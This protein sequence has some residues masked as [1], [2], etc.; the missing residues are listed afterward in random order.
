MKFWKRHLTTRL[1]SY[2]LLLSLVTVSAVSTVAYLQARH[3]LKASAFNQLNVAATLKEEEI[4]RWFEDQQRDFLLTMQLPEVQTRLQTLLT[5]PTSDPE[6]RQVKQNLAQYF[7]N[8]VDLKPN[9]QEV[10]VLDNSGRILLSS[11]PQREGL[12]E[13]AANVTF[14]EKV[15]VGAEFAPIF[16]PSPTTGKPVITFA[17]PI[18]NSQDRRIGLLVT[19][20]NLGRID[21]IIRQRKGLGR[22]GESYLVGFMVM[23][24]TFISATEAQLQ[25]TQGNVSSFGID[26][27]MRGMSGSGLYRNY[28]GTGVIG[29]YR[30]LNDRD[31]ALLVEMSQ[32]EAFAPARGLA[33]T[34]ILTGLVSAIALSVGVYWLSRKI[35]Q[36][37]LAIAET[38][39]QIT[40]GDLDREAPVLTE[41]EIGILA[42]NFNQM[43]RQ[44][45]VSRDQSQA[46]S[47][48]LEQKAKELENTLQKLRR[49]QAQLIQT[50]KMSSLGQL[51]A[52]MAHE[53]NN[54]INFIYGNLSHVSRYSEDLLNLLELY[55]RYYPQPVP[56]IKA[57]KDKVDVEFLIADLPQILESM[58]VGADRIS[59]IVKALRN[60]SR[61]D[62]AEK[63][64]VDIHEGIESTL[65]IMQS[66]LREKLNRP[67]IQVI[68]E[69]SKLPKVEC[70]AGQLNQ[71]IMHILTNAIDAFEEQ[72]RQ[73]LSSFPTP[74]PEPT[75]NI[76]TTVLTTDKN[77]WAIQIYIADNAMGMSPAIQAKIFDPFFTTKPVGS[78]TGLGLAISYSIVVE[79][80]GGELYCQSTP[81]K[82]TQ[83]TIEIPLHL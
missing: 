51:V 4:A 70:Y 77:P 32:A 27:A 52:G 55:D 82:G 63:K 12:I 46:Y 20:L 57:E 24:N 3:S 39:T 67:P 16:Y 80:H 17:T 60:F 30:W 62:Q 37:I 65:A 19:Q 36:P 79:R 75:I 41:D 31:L 69:Y 73:N 14:F 42:N 76:R 26:A 72:D 59:Q 50:E 1:A 74:I 2:F 23:G 58:Q 25:Q 22:T 29:V 45:K 49:T 56:E 7:D 81:G 11:Q 21:Q 35:A 40:A 34:I 61:L 71:V 28:A 47:N 78:G 43:V 33:A 15:E 10:Y 64:P 53:I 68:K 6:F 9:L 54:P 5:R 38:T 66:R 18:R 48:N 44:L 83:F 13:V 8:V